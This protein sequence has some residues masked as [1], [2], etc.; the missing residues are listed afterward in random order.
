M[1]P[2]CGAER[3]GFTSRATVAKVLFCGFHLTGA[4]QPRGRKAFARPPDWSVDLRFGRPT[5]QRWEPGSKWIT[6]VHHQA[7][8]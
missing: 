7:M 4:D 8:W 1:V 2:A 3:P 6:G 5:E